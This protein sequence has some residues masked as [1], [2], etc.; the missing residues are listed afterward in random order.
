MEQELGPGILF[1]PH[2]APMARGILATCH[3]EAA[4]PMEPD[5][6]LEVLRAAYAGEAFVAVIDDAPAVNWT[7]VRPAVHLV[8][9]TSSVTATNASPA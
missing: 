9:G 7:A 4:R 5:E 1:T 6:P 8:A 2:L 3:A